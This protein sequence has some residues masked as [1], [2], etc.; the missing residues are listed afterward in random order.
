MSGCCGAFTGLA[1]VL[2]SAIRRGQIC[3]PLC[4]LTEPLPDI[5]VE[6][7]VVIPT[8]EGKLLANIYKS[9]SMLQRGEKHPV[10]MCMHPYD[11]HITP[12]LGKTPLKG[13][14]QQYRLIP[15]A[16]KPRFSTQ[17]SWE[18]PDPNFWV[19]NGYAVVNLNAPGYAG[20]EGKPTA[21]QDSQAKAYY[22]A[23]EWVAAQDWCTGSVGLNGVSFLAITQYH[24]ATCRAYGGKAPPSLKCISPWEGVSDPRETFMQNGIP[25]VGFLAFWW[26]TEV[27]PVLTSGK[28]QDFIDSVGAKPPDWPN[29]SDAW[30]AEMCADVHNIRV[31]M[32]I[33]AS[34]SDHGLHTAGSLRAFTGASTKDKWLYTHRTG[35]W[36]AYYSCEVQALTLKFFD[37]FVKGID[38]GWRT[39][40]PPVRLEVRSARDVVH[41]VRSETTWP[42]PATQYTKLF[43]Q[44]SR[45][46]GVQ[47][48]SQPAEVCYSGKGG[49]VAFVFPFTEPTELTGHFALELVVE[50]RGAPDMAVFAAA[51]KLDKNGVFVPFR[52]S[53]GL[54]EDAVTRGCMLASLRELDQKKTKAHLPA[55]SYKRSPVTPGKKMQ[56]SMWMEA[57]STFFEAGEAIELVLSSKEIVLT[58]PYV[59]SLCGNTGTHV[60]H[61]GDSYLLVPK[62]QK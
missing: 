62:I 39:D 13:C 44:A 33:C 52:G 49:S 35:K 41:E 54:T 32:L 5:V 16:G 50:V 34:F 2:A 43:L 17:T 4:E 47:P 38:N 31:P 45:A 58:G 10:V 25:E 42:L 27:Q 53:T 24:V 21:F 56:L 15:Q 51:R 3:S 61:V 46:L 57:S 55:I 48:P 11:N 12:A 40:T 30:W 29:M 36:D 7:D 20:S 8:S 6:Y 59:K 19:A 37:Y 28:P 26:V 60:V 14:P 22:E 18:S 23:I 9:K 1:R